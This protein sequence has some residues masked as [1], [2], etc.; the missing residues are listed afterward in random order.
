MEAIRGRPAA[1]L[2]VEFSGDEAAEVA[3]R[4]EKLAA[5]WTGSTA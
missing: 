5:A 3:D 2:M 4:V 1:L